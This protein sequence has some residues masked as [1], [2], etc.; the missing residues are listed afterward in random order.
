MRATDGRAT[1]QEKRRP[2]RC[3][4]LRCR[5]QASAGPEGE[6]AWRFTV[7][8]AGLGSARRSFTCLKDL[9]AYLETELGSK[10]QPDH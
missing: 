4:L 6:P 5:L 10:N 1:K 2:Y 7:E 3:F 9:E 8:E